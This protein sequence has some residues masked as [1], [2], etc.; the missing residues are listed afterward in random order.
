ML[1]GVFWADSRGAWE[2]DSA[3]WGGQFPAQIYVRGIG[4]TPRHGEALRKEV[5]R[6]AI[7]EN[8]FSVTH[9]SYALNGTQVARLVDL[10]RQAG[11]RPDTPVATQAPQSRAFNEQ[12][13]RQ[14]IRGR[15]IEKPIRTPRGSR[16]NHPRVLKL[17]P[18][19]PPLPRRGKGRRHFDVVKGYRVVV[20]E[21]HFIQRYRPPDRPGVR[22]SH[23][24][25]CGNRQASEDRMDVEMEELM[26]PDPQSEAET[27]FTGRVSPSW[28]QALEV[29]REVGGNVPTT[30]PM[31]QPAVTEQQWT[32]GDVTWTDPQEFNRFLSGKGELPSNLEMAPQSLPAHPQQSLQQPSV[33]TS[34]TISTQPVN[35][36]ALLI[37]K[38]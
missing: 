33:T 23:R 3:A 34:R 27:R 16:G 4:A 8:F 1:Y 18:G 31:A 2:W 17:T 37:D 25:G 9:F 32:L 10:F 19:M 29:G 6:D 22:S 5:L 15:G 21:Q 28:G 26:R 7:A 35:V 12:P 14:Q 38:E 24:L 20:D 30:T 13:V 36:H 11:W